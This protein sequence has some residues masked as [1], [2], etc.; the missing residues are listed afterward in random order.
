MIPSSLGEVK[1]STPPTFTIYVCSLVLAALLKS[2]PLPLEP[3]S[4][5]PLT[6][7]Q[8]YAARKSS[9]IYN[10][11]DG[12]NGFYQGTANKDSRSRMNVTFRIEGGDEVEKRFVKLASEKGIKGVSG[13]RSV[14]GES[15]VPC[16]AHTRRCERV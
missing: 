7:L 16:R 10:E 6:P 3:A 9:L 4:A 1:T 5:P 14:G 13:H 8:E 2:P 11:L 12:S 15:I